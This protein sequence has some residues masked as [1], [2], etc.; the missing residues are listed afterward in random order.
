MP[1]LERHVELTEP[2]LESVT[3][4]GVSPLSIQFREAVEIHTLTT[5]DVKPTPPKHQLIQ[6]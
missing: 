5:R 4:Y 3:T 6:Q 1:R 2:C